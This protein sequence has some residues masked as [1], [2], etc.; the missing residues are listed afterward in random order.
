MKGFKEK[1]KHF[2]EVF[3][4]DRLKELLQEDSV[5]GQCMLLKSNYFD[6]A[7]ESQLSIMHSLF[8]IFQLIKVKVYS[9]N[10]VFAIQQKLCKKKLLLPE[11]SERHAVIGGRCSDTTFRIDSSSI[12]SSAFLF[13]K[14]ILP[15]IQNFAL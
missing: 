10:T 4:E 13:Q 11:P 12:Y 3:D 15:D 9:P 6:T 14:V 1:E 8:L 5:L 2:T 7:E